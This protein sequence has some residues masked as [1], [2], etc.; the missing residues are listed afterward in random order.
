MLTFNL[1]DGDLKLDDQG[2]LIF[3]KN[4]NQISVEDYITL[5]E[6]ENSKN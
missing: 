1:T 4:G 6:Q 3:D 2:Q 5:K